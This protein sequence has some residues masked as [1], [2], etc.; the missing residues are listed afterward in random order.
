MMGVFSMAILWALCFKKGTYVG[1][2]QD[3][4]WYIECIT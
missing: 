1:L 2:L 4:L 3:S